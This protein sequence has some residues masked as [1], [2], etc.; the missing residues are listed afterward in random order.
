MNSVK[1][2]L[3]QFYFQKI[4]KNSYKRSYFLL[5]LVFF[6]LFGCVFSGTAQTPNFSRIQPDNGDIRI[7]PKKSGNLQ[8]LLTNLPDRVILWN[9]TGNIL[10]WNIVDLNCQNPSYDIYVNET[11]NMTASWDS[12]DQIVFDLDNLPRGNYQIEIV[13][14]DGL[15]LQ[16][17]DSV[18]VSVIDPSIFGNEDFEYVSG[19]KGNEIEWIITDVN[20]SQPIFDIYR[21]NLKI[22]NGTWWAGVP[23][24]V[25]VDD[26]M[27]GV[28]NFTIVA[29][30]GNGNRF[31]DTVIVTVKS[32]QKNDSFD[33]LSR[34]FIWVYIITGVTCVTGIS[35]F[36]LSLKSHIAQR[37]I[38]PEGGESV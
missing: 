29:E 35:I 19:Q 10:V 15:G 3:E 25:I 2:I 6:G 31:R 30:D 9:S 18:L 12:E 4:K 8:P 20:E 11:L 13:C 24:V 32:E 23:I 7:N 1:T 5:G 17:N 26:L 16:S 27:I 37:R 34:E 14:Y 36:G 21:D 22:A 28:H 33:G 38:R